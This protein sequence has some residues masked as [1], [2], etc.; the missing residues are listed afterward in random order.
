M[1]AVDVDEYET[2]SASLVAETRFKDYESGNCRG[3]SI[4]MTVFLSIVLPVSLLMKKSGSITVIRITSGSLPI[5]MLNG[6]LN[7]NFK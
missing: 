3:K 5:D 7:S 4:S 1:D 2:S 6:S